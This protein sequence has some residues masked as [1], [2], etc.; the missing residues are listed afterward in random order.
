MGART[1]LFV[2][3]IQ[4]ELASDP[5][6]AIPH[7]A[8]IRG[9][10]SALLDRARAAIDESYPSSNLEIIIVQHAENPDDNPDATMIKGS[11]AWELVFPP[12]AACADER[13]V[14]K[15]TSTYM[16]ESLSHEIMGLM[17][18]S[19]AD[20]FASNPQLAQELRDRG[21]DTIVAFGIQSDYCVRATCKGAVN[22]GFP[23][24][25]LQGAHSTY[26]NSETEQTAEEIE[27]EIEEELKA[28]GVNVAPW[29]EYVF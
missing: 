12:R 27:R 15:T 14:G 25:L 21:V 10:G 20:T 5:T 17:V 7:A 6:T 3:D 26:D 4:S 28:I 16:K 18:V 1:A 9:A 24:V 2:I 23:V 22:A 29:D 8:R 11:K 13:L 19:V